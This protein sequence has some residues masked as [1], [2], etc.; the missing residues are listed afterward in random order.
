MKTAEAL[1]SELIEHVRPPQGCTIKLIE[2]LDNTFLNWIV[3]RGDM[4]N[5]D[6]E[7]FDKKVLHLCQT[8]PLV[9]WS[10]VNESED[11]PRALVYLEQAPGP[12][13]V[14]QVARR[15]ERS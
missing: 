15:P 8:D 4:T 5:A 7:R 6:R 10:G 14:L 9:D 1:L 11:S 12:R 13:V 2:H 3:I